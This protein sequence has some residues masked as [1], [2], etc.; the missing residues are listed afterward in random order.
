MQKAVSLLQ[1]N[2]RIK[3]TSIIVVVLLCICTCVTM[4]QTQDTVTQSPVL[5]AI[6]PEVNKEVFAAV[7]ELPD[8]PGGM[9]K[10]FSFLRKN[11]KKWRGSPGVVRVTFVVEKDGSLSDIKTEGNYK[12][13][14]GIKEAI[15]VFESSP[16]WIPGKQNG[17]PVRVQFTVPVVF[18]QQEQVRS[19]T[20]PS[21]Y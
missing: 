14:A 16:K 15:R 12:D 8:F 2:N 4:A 17:N 21:W 7:E 11:L 6:S 1:M 10:M 3:R 13:E 9:D 18:E 5:P 19:S 20:Y